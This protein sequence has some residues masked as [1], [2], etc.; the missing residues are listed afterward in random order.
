MTAGLDVIPAGAALAAFATEFDPA[1]RAALQSLPVPGVLVD[2]RLIQAGDEDALLESESNSIASGL[3]AVRR[4]SGAARIVARRLLA[5][6]GCPTCALP[7]G[8]TGAPSWPAGAI[9]SL[10]HD[11]SVAVAAVARAGAFRSI[12]IDIE[13]AVP[14][15]AEMIELVT[16]PR[17]RA[18]LD[19]DP[20][21]GR[22][23][24]TA[25]EA[26]YKAVQPID[27]VFLEFHDIEVD[28]DAGR[29]LVRSE[30][31]VNIRF[32]AASHVVALVL[33]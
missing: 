31:A 20:L 4:A 12:G 19:G 25:K 15:P 28:L 22:L 14:L 9:G 5:A 17:E 24:F 10:A 6:I 23:Y 8:P 26:V 30:R 18:T 32:C 33:L 21:R 11:Q 13:P 1:L 2:H 27:P 16:T 29:A 3:V 7:K